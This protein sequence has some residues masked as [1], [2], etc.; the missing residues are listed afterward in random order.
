MQRIVTQL[1][2]VAGLLILPVAA[3]D[4]EKKLTFNFREAPVD[5]VLSYVSE[6]TGWKFV[7]DNVKITGTVTAIS[8]GPVSSSQILVV[9]DAALRPHGATTL[10]PYAPRLPKSG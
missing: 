7:F 6:V 3:Q 10:N 8:D 2:I 5:Q 9:L 4:D 1:V